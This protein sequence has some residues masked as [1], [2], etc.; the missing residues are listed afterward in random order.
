M[1][2]IP[3]LKVT[4]VE[5]DEGVLKIYLAFWFPPD[6]DT[7]NKGWRNVWI[8]IDTQKMRINPRWSTEWLIHEPYPRDSEVWMLLAHPAIAIPFTVLYYL[9]WPI[10]FPLSKAHTALKY[11][12]GLTPLNHKLLAELQGKLDEKT[13]DTLK[14]ALQ[15]EL[16]ISNYLA[17]QINFEGAREFLG[18]CDLRVMEYP[19]G[20]ILKL[21]KAFYWF[22]DDGVCVANAQLTEDGWHIFQVLGTDFN[23]SDEQDA[24][25]RLKELTSR[26]RSITTKKWKKRD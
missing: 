17:Q 16:R 21:E 12:D 20:A 18:N 10:W 14:L 25:L 3:P 19:K 9:S 26:Y 23:E 5:R 7:P 13:V 6:I 15:N 22:N 2:G 1:D 8:S 24:L 4:R 11:R